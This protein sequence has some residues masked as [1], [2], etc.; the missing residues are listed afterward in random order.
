MYK[1][2][3]SIVILRNHREWLC[4]TGKAIEAYLDGTE[5]SIDITS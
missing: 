5:E 2:T 4:A 3:Y 1:G